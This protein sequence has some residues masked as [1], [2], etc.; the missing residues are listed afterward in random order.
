MWSCVDGVGNEVGD[1]IAVELKLDILMS[2]YEI[3]EK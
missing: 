3:M 2:L 1:V